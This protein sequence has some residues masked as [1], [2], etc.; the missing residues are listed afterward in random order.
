MKLYRGIC[1]KD[2][3]LFVNWAA[4]LKMP[5]KVIQYHL[6]TIPQGIQYF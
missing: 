1:K 2:D 3:N 4:P 6:V 5:P